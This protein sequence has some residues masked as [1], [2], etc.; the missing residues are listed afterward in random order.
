MQHIPKLSIIL[1]TYNHEN[2]IAQA[3]DSILSQKVNF[4]YEVIIAEDCSTDRTKEII[5][6]YKNKFKNIKIIFNKKN[7]GV[8]FTFFM[9]K[10]NCSDT[11]YIA[12]FEGDDYWTDPNK[13]QQQVDFLD[14]NPAFVGCSHNTEL[15]YEQDGKREPMIAG[16]SK[17]KSVCDIKDL[18]SG[19]CYFH[20]SSYVW[21]N[22]F[23][24][25]YPK[26]MAY[27]QTV[28]GDWF[29]SMLYARN[30]NIKYIDKVMSVYRI[31]GNGRFS[32]L[33]QYQKHLSNIRGIY[34]YNKLLHYEY[35]EEFKRIWWA[36]K[37]VI[38][39][40]P[41]NYKT[42]PTL[43]KLYLLKKSIDVTANKNFLITFDRIKN[44]LD[45]RLSYKFKRLKFY[46]FFFKLFIS[47]GKRI[48][49]IIMRLYEFFFNCFYFFDINR[50]FLFYKIN[51]YKFFKIK[52]YTNKQK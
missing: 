24:D 37:D 8:C 30:G 50:Y 49:E 25:G 26:E 38:K 6:K 45:R 5:L 47:L 9:S 42:C 4:E 39:T 27:N 29:L 36:C 19:H 23:K 31:T 14:N 10:F 22:L 44:I 40:T 7:Y 35:N 48:D 1:Q 20:T 52:Y 17:I 11:Q 21:R 2:Y 13:L 3:L 34:I 41:K 28:M 43:I 51:F 33:Q 32:K 18:I 46:K 16:G 12:I 15:L